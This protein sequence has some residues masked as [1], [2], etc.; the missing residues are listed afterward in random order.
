VGV[1]MT[2]AAVAG[3]AGSTR[4]VIGVT[5]VVVA[6]GA[7]IAMKLLV[8]GRRRGWWWTW[9]FVV[10]SIVLAAAGVCLIVAIGG[11]SCPKSGCGAAGG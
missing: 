10:L 4:L 3:W 9:S 11:N 1:V 8:R 6:V 5:S 2:A 7:G